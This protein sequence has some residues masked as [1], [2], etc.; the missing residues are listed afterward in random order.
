[1]GVAE[2]GVG[3]RGWGGGAVPDAKH[4]MDE[5]LTIRYSL[6]FSTIFSVAFLAFLHLAV[7]IQTYSLINCL[8][9]LNK[10]LS[11]SSKILA[12][13]FDFSLFFFSFPMSVACKC[14]CVSL[15]H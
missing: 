4:G 6:Y 13:C 2:L 8:M 7:F 3:V 10:S 12:A 5:P 14:T 15:L 1:M 11:L 9:Y